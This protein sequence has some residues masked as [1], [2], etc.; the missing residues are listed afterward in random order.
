MKGKANS[1]KS[2]HQSFIA[3]KLY[4]W[5]ELKIMGALFLPVRDCLF[6]TVKTEDKADLGKI[7]RFF[8]D[9]YLV[10]QPFCP[11]PLGSD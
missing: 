9:T 3:K 8:P 10:F 11:F 7:L 1:W 2:F 4:Y 5:P 6:K